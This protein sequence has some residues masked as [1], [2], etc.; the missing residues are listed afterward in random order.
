MSY[1]L[2]EKI[3][4]A[5]A[6]SPAKAGDFVVARVDFTMIHDAR[7]ENALKQLEKLGAK[8]LPHAARTALVLDHYSPPPTAEA[9]NTQVAMWRFADDRR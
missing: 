7:A 4:G 6:G 1:T 5:H 3:L 2:A 9:A 8:E